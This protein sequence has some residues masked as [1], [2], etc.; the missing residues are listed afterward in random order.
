MSVSFAAELLRYRQTRI[1]SVGRKV[2]ISHASMHRFTN[3]F[4]TESRRFMPKQTYLFTAVY[5]CGFQLLLLLCGVLV[6]LVRVLTPYFF[7]YLVSHLLHSTCKTKCS[8]EN[9][10]HL[11]RNN[12]WRM[13]CKRSTFCTGWLSQNSKWSLFPITIWKLASL[14]QIVGESTSKFFILQLFLSWIRRINISVWATAHLHL[15]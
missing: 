9:P 6:V 13:I 10:F 15:P 14:R 7:W 5:L 1:D 4:T 3:I 12:R 8:T 2:N 11:S